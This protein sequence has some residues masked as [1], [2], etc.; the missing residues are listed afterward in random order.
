MND[1]LQTENSSIEMHEIKY[2]QLFFQLV[3][4]LGIQFSIF[5]QD[6][7]YDAAV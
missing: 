2:S 5:T 6:E 4:S 3:K 1:V 7:G